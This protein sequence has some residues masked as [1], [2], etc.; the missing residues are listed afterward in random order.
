LR[1]REETCAGLKA[2]KVYAMLFIGPP[3]S[4]KT[5]M[6]LSLYEAI[7]TAAFLEHAAEHVEAKPAE[8]RLE[9]R[10]IVVRAGGVRAEVEFKL[11]KGSEADFLPVQDVAQAL[12]LYK[13]LKA[14]GVPVKVTPRGVKVDREAMWA[15]VATAVERGAPSRLPAEVMP[16]VELLNVHSAGG[17]KMYIF[18]AEGVH[19]YFLVKTREGWRAAGG[20]RAKWQVQIVG[21]AARAIA[22]A[23]NT[24]YR[25]RGVDRRVEVRLLKDGTPYII[26]TN[27]DLELLGIR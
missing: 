3:G 16:G 18:R 6:P 12:T 26:L 8:V 17:V 22:D 23:I 2:P 13:S 21:E 14:L 27:V 19:Y 24:L 9:G 11:L 15:L 7:P 4:G 20:K 10:R 25:E 1:K 5:H